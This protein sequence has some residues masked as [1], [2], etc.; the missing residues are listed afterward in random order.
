MTHN[1][2]IHIKY[3]NPL[4]KNRDASVAARA[5]SLTLVSLLT[6][7]INPYHVKFLKWNNPSYI[8]GTFYYHF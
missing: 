2:V 4:C 1:T 3:V 5:A 6:K 8:Y 7:V